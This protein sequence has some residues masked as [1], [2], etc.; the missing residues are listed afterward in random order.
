MSVLFA[1]DPEN[2]GETVQ[3][4]KPGNDINSKIKDKKN[5]LKS[6]LKKKKLAIERTLFYF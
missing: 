1:L 5:A 2:A 6:S 4:F 3:H